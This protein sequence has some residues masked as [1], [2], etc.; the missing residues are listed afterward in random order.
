[1]L[2]SALELPVSMFV[3]AERFHFMWLNLCDSSCR[4]TMSFVSLDEK[5]RPAFAKILGYTHTVV[6]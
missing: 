5:S 1:V 3:K 6:H 2:G 4:P